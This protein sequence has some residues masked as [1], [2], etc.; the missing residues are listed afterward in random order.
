MPTEV[1]NLKLNLWIQILC[2][3][4]PDGVRE[5]IFLIL[6]TDQNKKSVT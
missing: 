1:I 3:G 2:S 5:W 4:F 6:C